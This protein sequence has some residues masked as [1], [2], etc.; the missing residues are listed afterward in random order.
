MLI[1]LHNCLKGGFVVEIIKDY[2]TKVECLPQRSK[3]PFRDMQVGDGFE[4]PA[5]EKGRV[6]SAQNMFGKRHGKK[7]SVGNVNRDVCFCIRVA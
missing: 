3:Y 6:N 1:E 5:S 7:F 2:A 4:F